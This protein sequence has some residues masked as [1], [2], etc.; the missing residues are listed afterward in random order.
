[1]AANEVDEYKPD[2]AVPPGATLQEI[3][4][5]LGMTQAEPKAELKI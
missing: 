3:M 2:Y 5:D 4:D 1:M